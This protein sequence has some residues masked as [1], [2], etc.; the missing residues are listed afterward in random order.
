MMI[1]SDTIYA[2]LKQQV[3]PEQ[4]QGIGRIVKADGS[5]YLQ[6]AAERIPIELGQKGAVEEGETVRYTIDKGSIT[7]TP[8]STNPLQD[9]W[10]P[11]DV[12]T[13]TGN[14]ETQAAQ[15]SSP[16][17]V[18]V[19]G[20]AAGLYLFSSAEDALAFMGQDKNEKLLRQLEKPLSIE[21]VITIKIEGAGNEPSRA[22]IYAA[23]EIIPLLRALRASF[24]GMPLS[25]L[26]IEIWRQIL[27][28][29]GNLLFDRLH[30]LNLLLQGSGISFPEARAGSAEAQN[31][32]IVQWLHSAILF[33][34]PFADL[35]TLAPA[36]SASAVLSDLESSLPLLPHDAGIPTAIPE[37]FTLNDSMIAATHADPAL[38]PAL[39]D[40]C[41]F[42][43]EQALASPEADRARFDAGQTL[44]S[45][46]LY[47]YS[48]TGSPETE[49]A[50]PG[51]TGKPPSVQPRVAAPLLQPQQAPD[52]IS[53]AADA[54]FDAKDDILLRTRLAS[55]R[56]EMAAFIRRELPQLSAYLFVRPDLR[57]SEMHNSVAFIPLSVTASETPP[58][59]EMHPAASQSSAI[60]TL[61]DHIRSIVGLVS[62]QASITGERNAGEGENIHAGQSRPAA[63]IATLS[64]ITEKCARLI[65][66]VST[67]ALS[68][69]GKTSVPPGPA[70]V[71]ATPVPLPAL[72]RS[73]FETIDALIRGFLPPTA[74]RAAGDRRAAGAETEEHARLA[75]GRSLLEHGTPRASM[76]MLQET[77]RETLSS[78][79]D[80]LESLQLL[81]RHVS[82]NQGTQQIIALPIKFG[83][84]WTEINVRFLHHKQRKTKKGSSHFSVYLDVAPPA[85]GA[86]HARLEYRRSRHLH[87]SI[88]FERETARKWFTG[89]HDAIHGAL[90][91]AGAAAVRLD[92]KQMRKTNA[93]SDQRGALGGGVIDLTA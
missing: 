69:T 30:E 64:D 8:L 75:I 73:V 48:L 19:S 11:S 17:G 52:T 67:P 54:A 93:S 46:L 80:R 22:V 77:L 47:L 3:M 63:V 68:T 59:T 76:A 62:E 72:L 24:N 29:R 15:A 28:D 21:G 57:G 26:P 42:T 78:A 74:E 38:L 83:D 6:T 16:S 71:A 9:Q 45:M 20:L 65:D 85:V 49:T 36:S 7:L 13:L 1:S 82:T 79:L 70:H 43:L 5:Y 90:R 66:E 87:L 4:R 34:P 25:S 91:A 33:D 35:A 37:T 2:V 55:L 50:H 92:F 18:P 81:A 88:E 23:S 58:S 60:K 44:K 12:F 86:L 40:R 41:G 31:S 32:A 56:H 53:D 51:I 61:I 10:R 39:I 27:F 14:A 84:T 89:H